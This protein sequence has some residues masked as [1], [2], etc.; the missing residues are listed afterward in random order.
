MDAAIL[1]ASQQPPDVT[2]MDAADWVDMRLQVPQDVGVARVF[3][4]SIVWQYIP[5]DRRQR[6]HDA[7]YA[8]GAK[9]T[10]DQPLAWIMLETNRA[11]FRHELTIRY[12][13]GGEEPHILAT[14]QAH[15]AWIEWL[16]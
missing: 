16:D 6:I 10:A 11:T 7:I 4:H 8:A 9:A 2:A 15:G 12:W 3:N 1:L 5:E 14:A 13:P